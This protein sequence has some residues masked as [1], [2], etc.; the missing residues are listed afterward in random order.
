MNVV[1]LAAMLF[2]GSVLSVQMLCG[3]ETAGNLIRNPEFKLVKGKLRYWNVRNGKAETMLSDGSQKGVSAVKMPV[4]KT[5]SKVFK[6][7]NVFS[8]TII[9]P[10]AGTYVVTV[11]FSVS[12]KFDQTLVLV[13][14]K[15]PVSGKYVYNKDGRLKFRD[16][17]EPGKWKKKSVIVTIPENVQRVDFA[18]EVR[19][20]KPGGTVSV[21]QPEFMLR[22]E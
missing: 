19:D 15:D 14:Y 11:G 12:R 22:E 8:Q 5:K 6:Y 16:Y 1:K 17:S 21:E 2:A 7:G 9:R 13:Y 4:L 3:A 10:A 18:V 20:N